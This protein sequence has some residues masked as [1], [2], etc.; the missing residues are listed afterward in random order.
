MKRKRSE[1]KKG[2]GEMY[3]MGRGGERAASGEVWRGGID[4]I[5]PPFPLHMDSLRTSD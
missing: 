2:R 3:K 5:F 1:E 4:L